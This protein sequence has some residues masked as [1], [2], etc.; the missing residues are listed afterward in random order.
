MLEVSKARKIL[1]EEAPEADED[2]RG[3]LGAWSPFVAAFL[4]LLSEDGELFR[5]CPAEES[6]VD[7]QTA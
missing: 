3:I 2:V 5:E 1:R 6:T 7:E 4:E